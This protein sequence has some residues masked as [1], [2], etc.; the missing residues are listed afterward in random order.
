M[1]DPDEVDAAGLPMTCRAVFIIGTAATSRP[2]SP[3]SARVK[4]VPTSAELEPFCA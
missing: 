2:F 1:M 4:L 3:A